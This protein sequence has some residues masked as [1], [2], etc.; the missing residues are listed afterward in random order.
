MEGGSVPVFRSMEGLHLQDYPYELS[1]RRSHT[2]VTILN[3]S[4]AVRCECG[5]SQGTP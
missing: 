1:V 2:R 3:Y 5:G 4:A